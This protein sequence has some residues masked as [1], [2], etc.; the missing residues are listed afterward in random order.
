MQP[1]CGHIPGNG[2]GRAFNT[3]IFAV[4]NRKA[5]KLLLTRWRDLLLDPQK[6]TTVVSWAGPLSRHTAPAAA[7]AAG[8]HRAMVLA[9]RLAWLPL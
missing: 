5:G 2:W 3:G 4:R 7:P 8:L 9:A 1:R 6:S